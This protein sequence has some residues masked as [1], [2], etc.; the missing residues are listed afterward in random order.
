MLAEIAFYI[1]FI[2]THSAMGQGAEAWVNAVQA[3]FSLSMPVTGDKRRV[4]PSS[5]RLRRYSLGV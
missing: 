5:N 2:E 3:S 1:A 4:E